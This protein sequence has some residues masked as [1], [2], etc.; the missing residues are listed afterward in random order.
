MRWTSAALLALGLAV[1]PAG[2]LEL[3]PVARFVWTLADEDFGGFS[4]LVVT[5]AGRRLWAVS[6]HGTLWHA[7]IARDAEGRITGIG[8]PWHDRFQDNHGNPVSGFTS[9]SE[10]ITAAPDGGFFIGYESYSRVAGLHPP[11]MRPT[12]LHAFERFKAEWSNEGFE[13]LARRADGSLLAVVERRDA[14]A[15][16]Y[17]TYIGHSFDWRPGPILK[18][19]PGFGA[20]DLAIDAD[21]LLWLL[22]RRLTW[23]GQFEIRISTC[24]DAAEGVVDCDPVMLPGSGELGNMEGLSIWSD[25]HGREFI[26]LISDDNF[27]MLSSTAIVEYELLR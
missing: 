22:E 3:R 21:G 25:T 10:A 7:E 19:G 24:A 16:G 9:D 14:T 23:L 8:T 1:G 2:A 18:A 13:G 15:G 17:R 27:S 5:D 26:S 11:D 12:P 6:D 4:G 20:S